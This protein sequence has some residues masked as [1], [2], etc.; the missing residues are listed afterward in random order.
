MRIDDPSDSPSVSLRIICSTRD[1]C[2]QIKQM[3]FRLYF[4]FKKKK[5]KQKKRTDTSE[6]HAIFL[7]S[8]AMNGY[9]L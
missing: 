7:K 4:S 8:L 9:S 2:L 5:K 1:K 6:S 3:N